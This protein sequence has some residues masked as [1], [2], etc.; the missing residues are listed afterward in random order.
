MSKIFEFEKVT[1]VTVVP[2][3]RAASGY[4]G[5]GIFEGCE[6]HLQ[7]DGRTLKIFP[8]KPRGCG[9]CWKCIDAAGAIPMGYVLC[10][11]CGNKR[12]PHAADHERDCT[13][14]NAPGQPG[15]TRYPAPAD[16]EGNQP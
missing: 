11:E 4:E 8:A 2:G 1:R 6:I 13:R 16:Q 10:P 14:S 7:D 12:C 9:E 3:N 15:A 5:W